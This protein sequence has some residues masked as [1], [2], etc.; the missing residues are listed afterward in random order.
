MNATT[1]SDPVVTQFRETMYRLYYPQGL[2]EQNHADTLTR[3]L[4]CTPI[5]GDN[6][7]ISQWV[8]SVNG[9]PPK[10]TLLI[11]G[12]ADAQAHVFFLKTKFDQ[13]KGSK[14]L[15][16]IHAFCAK[17]LKGRDSAFTLNA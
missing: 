15:E 12:K 10:G 7:T 8:I 11:D 2:S 14:Q 6:E 4:V 16:N 13:V 17:Y 9:S 1:V 5:K 3:P